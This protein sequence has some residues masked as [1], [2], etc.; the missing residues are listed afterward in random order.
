MGRTF[1]GIGTACGLAQILWSDIWSGV[2]HIWSE[3]GPIT[4][5]CRKGQSQITSQR[6]TDWWNPFHLIVPHRL[7]SFLVTL[8]ADIHWTHQ[9]I[10]PNGL[11]QPTVLKLSKNSHAT[12]MHVNPKKTIQ[13]FKTMLSAD[14]SQL[15]LELQKVWWSTMISFIT[16]AICG[17]S[18]PLTKGMI[19]HLPLPRQCTPTSKFR[20]DLTPPSGT[21]WM[22]ENFTCE[23]RS[24]AVKMWLKNDGKVLLGILCT[25]KMN[26]QVKNLAKRGW[27]TDG[28]FLAEKKLG[29]LNANVGDFP[30]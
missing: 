8:I 4:T 20:I 15:S 9:R 18:V 19:Q 12:A 13:L 1:F 10:S 22:E 17:D 21:Q 24:K 14:H 26:E 11:R 7:N 16:A 3:P 27:L 2:S 28:K 30:V 25:C 23:E 6:S 5:N 29:G